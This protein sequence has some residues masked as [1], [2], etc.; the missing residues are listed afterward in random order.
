MSGSIKDK[1]AYNKPY[2]QNEINNGATNVQ[3]GEK[4]I[5]ARRDSAVGVSV[6]GVS[7]AFHKRKVKQTGAKR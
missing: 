7:G 4:G 5:H 2:R 1:V 3:N 6:G